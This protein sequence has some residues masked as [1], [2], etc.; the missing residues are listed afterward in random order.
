LL[1]DDNDELELELDDKSELKLDDERLELDGELE[2]LP[3]LK[4][5]PVIRVAAQSA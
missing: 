1:L 4:L 5:Q 3:P 2:E